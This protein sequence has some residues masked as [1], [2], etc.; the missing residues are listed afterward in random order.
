[1]S[2]AP[3]FYQ[4]IR[5]LFTQYDRI[6]MMFYADLWDYE[7]VKER[8]KA[9]HLSLQPLEPGDNPG[10]W[11]KL[12]EVHIMPVGT[13]PWPRE[14]IDLF[15]NWIEN[16]CQEGMAPPPPPTPGPGVPAFLALSRKVTGFDDLDILGD[17]EALAQTYI[18][19]LRRDETVSK[20]LD[21]LLTTVG[22]DGADAIIAS[23]GEISADFVE[24][25]DV[26]RTI[27]VSWYTGS[28]NG[29]P[30]APE[31]N[32]YVNGLQWRAVQAHPM[33]F[34]NMNVP[35]YWKFKPEADDYTGLIS[36]NA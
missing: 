28:V 25:K 10:G 35:F 5:P 3:T 34:A 13:G 2:Q 36:W 26:L 22:S 8:A 19:R 11:S 23:D 24:Y 31:W 6:M 30:G 9:I 1:M 15:G 32:T 16:G 14:N 21:A 29:N 33:G 27:A 18:D 20:Q 12:P 4:D 7:Q 17:A